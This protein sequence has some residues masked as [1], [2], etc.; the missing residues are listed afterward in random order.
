MPH[1]IG[2]PISNIKC[3]S[4]SVLCNNVETLKDDKIKWDIEKITLSS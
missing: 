1:R 4:S 2:L 3:T